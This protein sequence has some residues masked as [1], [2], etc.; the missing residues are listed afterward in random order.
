[1][2]QKKRKR[3]QQNPTQNTPIFKATPVVI[4]TIRNDKEKHVKCTNS[5]VKTIPKPELRQINKQE[6]NFRTLEMTG[7]GNIFKSILEHLSKNSSKPLVLSGPT[8][9]GKTFGIDLC[10]KIANRVVQEINP[11]NIDS[12]QKLEQII[13]L[14]RKTKSL[15]GPKLIV[16]D[17]LEGFDPCY[18]KI[19][20]NILQ[21]NKKSDAPIILICTNRMSMELKSFRPFTSFKLNAINVENCINI[22]TLYSK[23][24]LLTIRKIANECCGNLKQLELRLQYKS[25]KIDR[26]YNI[27]YATQLL[28]K[29]S[30]SVT[31]WLNSADFSNLAKIIYENYPS[32]SNSIEQCSRMADSLSRC[33]LNNA[34]MSY[35]NDEANFGL[36]L[37]SSNLHDSRAPLSLKYAPS[38]LRGIQA[39][40]NQQLYNGQNHMEAN[41]Q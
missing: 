38:H 8:G 16:I 17:D 20:Y 21:T 35:S 39:L 24:S 9:C 25:A 31:T 5:I 40:S 29:K 14:A 41:S 15:C 32:T 13:Y 26:D 2:L 33:D 12:T 1:M 18:L 19:M 11:A 37:Q 22:A 4:Q 23:S 10:A 28:I 30:I 27:F 3:I 34:Y 7:N 6:N 36:G